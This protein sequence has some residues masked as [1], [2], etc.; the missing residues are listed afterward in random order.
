MSNF[1]DF[2]DLKTRISIE[3]VIPILD[4]SLKQ[5]SNQ[6]RGPCP[7]CDSESDR[8]LV[9]TPSKE[10]FYCFSAKDGG[11][12]IALV[13]HIL[14]K[15]M[16][17]AAAYIS[18]QTNNNDLAELPPESMSE[19]SGLRPL[20]YL[21]TDHENVI[22]LGLDAETCHY[23]GAG[24][25]PKGIMRGR[26]AIPVHDAVGELVAYCGRSVKSDQS[27]VLTFPKGFNPSH[28]RFNL[29]R[30]GTGEL[31]CLDDPLDVLLAYQNGV[32]NVISVLESP[33]E[34]V[35]SL[36]VNQQA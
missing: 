22:N 32:E 8:T 12:V 17:E 24:Y 15:S 6:Y 31:Y 5:Q 9:I 26:L 33:S 36:P 30:V 18:D 13:A 3:S 35:V 20:D 4:L 21:V 23:F 25:A 34:N 7:A 28:Y 2:A 16:K 11:D 29:H 1:I 14:G 19:P 10:A 27:P